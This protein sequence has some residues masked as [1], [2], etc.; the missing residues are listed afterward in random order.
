MVT[1]TKKA[2]I[3]SILGIAGITGA[4][5][6]FITSN[7]TNT[8]SIESEKVIEPIVHKDI[9]YAVD[10]YVKNESARKAKVKECSNNPGKLMETPNCSNASQ[11][12]AKASIGN[13]ADYGW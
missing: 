1:V 6:F 4:S 9:V 5:T 12:A 2:L 3:I 7:V 8:T 11:A 10:W 13:P